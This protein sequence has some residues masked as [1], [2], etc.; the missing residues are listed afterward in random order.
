MHIFL[1]GQ[2]MPAALT[3]HIVLLSVAV[4]RLHLSLCSIGMVLYL[5]E[6]LCFCMSTAGNAQ[7]PRT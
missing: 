6:Q 5:T 2:A 4:P 1:H 7:N 3:L